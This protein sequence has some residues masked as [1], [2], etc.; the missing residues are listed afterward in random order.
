MT[1]RTHQYNTRYQTRSHLKTQ[2]HDLCSPPRQDADVLGPVS[3]VDL[4]SGNPGHQCEAVA[5]AHSEL[6]INNPLR[7]LEA[8]VS[9]ALAFKVQADPTGGGTVITLD[10]KVHVPAF[11]PPVLLTTR[12]HLF[13]KPAVVKFM[14]IGIAGRHRVRDLRRV[15]GL[16]QMDGFLGLWAG[17][18]TLS[19]LRLPPHAPCFGS[20]EMVALAVGQC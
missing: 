4:T 20:T 8:T 13:Q 12:Q 17:L 3:S 15:S 10:A 11:T 19:P 16:V 5:D 7:A 1:A 9:T 14:G 2:L 18:L 6:L